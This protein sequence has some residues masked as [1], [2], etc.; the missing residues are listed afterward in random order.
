MPNL[1]FNEFILEHDDILRDMEITCGD[2][3]RLQEEFYTRYKKNPRI[4]EAIIFRCIYHYFNLKGDNIISEIQSG[5]LILRPEKRYPAEF[6]NQ[7]LDIAILEDSKIKV[8]ISVKMSSR[9]PAYLDGADFSNPILM[10]KYLSYILEKQ[11]NLAIYKEEKRRIKVPTLLQDMAR[12][13]NIQNNQL[14]RFQSITIIYSSKKAGDD[15]WVTEFNSRF[16]HTFLYLKDNEHQSFFTL[17]E[18]ILSKLNRGT[19]I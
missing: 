15:F 2:I 17:L 19:L 13:E 18:P 5:S 7:N 1:D 14:N 10:E 9:T 3:I 16:Q 8:G 6:G 11:E 4:A 12:I